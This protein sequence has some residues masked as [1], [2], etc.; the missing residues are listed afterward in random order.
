MSKTQIV[1]VRHRYLRD[2]ESVGASSR[3]II[4]RSD[5]GV[6]TYVNDAFRAITGI[7]PADVVGRP[8]ES[9]GHPDDQAVVLPQRDEAVRRGYGR[10]QH[11]LRLRTASGGWCWVDADFSVITNPDTGAA[12]VHA[13]ARPAPATDE[14]GAPDEAVDAAAGPADDG[15][16]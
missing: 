2:L 14:A 8:V 13:H 10:F 15:A 7:D 5:A 6:I 9:I 3:E 12:E 4:Y 16:E 11:R 1:N